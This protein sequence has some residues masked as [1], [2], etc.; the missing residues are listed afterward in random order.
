MN[1]LYKLGISSETIKTMLEMNPNIGE[2]SDDEV[3]QKEE[4]LKYIGCS[5]REMLN[6]ISSNAMYLD[7]TEEDILKLIMYLK[8]FG[9]SCLNI[10][11]D[12]NPYILNLDVYE[13]ENY[14]KS[15]LDNNEKLEDIVD[16]M[17]S[18]PYLFNE[19]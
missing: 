4:L 10:L 17:D 18:N 13:I 1:E 9:F 5:D 8:K 16:D 14:I 11:F 12:A 7:R 15:R 3:K 19:I 6:I 2:L